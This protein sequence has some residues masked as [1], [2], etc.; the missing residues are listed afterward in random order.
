MI[1]KYLK[2]LLFVAVVLTAGLISCKKYVDPPPIF[3]VG[4]SLVVK[5]PRKLLLIAIDGIPGA[6]MKA[7]M[8]TNIAGLLPNSKYSWDVLAEVNTTTV[9]SWK[10]L[11]SKSVY[12]LLSIFFQLHFN[13]AAKRPKNR[14]YNWVERS[15]PLRCA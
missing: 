2:A 1:K 3:E 15:D 12:S 7:I 14:F 13:N 6:E 9:A 5:P 11:L 10:T 4:D 8:P